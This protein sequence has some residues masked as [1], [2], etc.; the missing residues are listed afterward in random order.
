MREK[1]EQLIL[2]HG[3]EEPEKF[4]GAV[5][6]PVFLNSLHVFPTMEAYLEAGQSE[7]TFTYRR[8]GNPTT[9]LL[10]QKMAALECGEKACAFASGMAATA[11]A[12]FAVCSAG[13][14]IIY[15]KNLYGPVRRL[16]ENF[17]VQRLG[18]SADGW[19]GTDLQ[20]LEQKLRPETRLV[21]LESP[22]TFVMT[23]ADLEG[24]SGICRKRGIRTCIDNTW[25]TPLLQKTLEFGIDIV[26]HTLTKYVGGHSDMMGGI[27]ISRDAGLIEEIR[28]GTGELF[29]GTLGPTEAWLAIRGLRTL[30]IRLKKHQET[31]M[32]VA[33]FLESRPEV[34][35]VY[36]TGLDSHPQRNLIQKQMKGHSG[37]LS[38]LLKGDKERALKFVN[39][40]ALFQKG[41][42]WGGYESLALCPLYETPDEVLS[43]IGLTGSH[44]GLIRLHCGLEGEE[45]L[46]EDLQNAFD[47]I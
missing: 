45:N 25:C 16:L 1:E 20:E 24:V 15:M 35:R 39:R 21:L 9:A 6:P 13:S 12:I 36:Y 38:F 22:A 47:A 40:L 14:H 43:R 3:G 23:V 29:G 5:N 19:S 32:K 4:L 42:S 34:E 44:R 33:A 18:M 17:C 37:L 8:S 30:D 10:E 28:S 46:L 11:A 31:A 7:G 26:M 41:C 27:L 2:T